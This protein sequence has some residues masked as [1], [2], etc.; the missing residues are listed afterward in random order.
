MRHLRVRDFVE[1]DELQVK[2][3]GTKDMLAD[4][5]T[6]TLPGPAL[7]EMRDKVHLVFSRLTL[8]GSV[9]IYA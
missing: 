1:T 9:V 6:K 7:A 5:M 2:W 3:I 4:G 8:W